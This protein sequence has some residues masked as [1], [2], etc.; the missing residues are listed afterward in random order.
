MDRPGHD[1]HY[2]IDASKIKAA[3]NWVPHHTFEEGMT[4]TI[5]WYLDH[6]DWV[7]RVTS[8]TYRDYYKRQYG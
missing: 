8:G 6:Q 7:S 2:A 4:K 1:Q 5:R 3:L